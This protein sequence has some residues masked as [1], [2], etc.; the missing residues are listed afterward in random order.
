MKYL[1]SKLGISIAVL[2]G[3][4]QSIPVANAVEVS[5]FVDRNP[6]YLDE[7]VTLVVT[8]EDESTNIPVPD[9]EPLRADFDI[10][11]QSTQTNINIVNNVPNV[12]QSW[13]IEIQPRRLGVIEIPAL[14]IAGAQTQP[15]QLE[16]QRYVSN[17]AT[18]GAEIFLEVDVTSNNPGH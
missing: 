11:S 2:M 14:M 7:S 4:M 10:L 8:A 9:L 3:L 17:V 6:I 15:I 18:E 16:V 12:V 5:A 13:V 1:G